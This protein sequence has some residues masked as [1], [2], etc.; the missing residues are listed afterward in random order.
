MVVTLVVLVVVG[1]LASLLAQFWTEILWFDSVDLRSV[2]ATQLGAQVLL[3][4]LSGLLAAGVVFSSL[5]IGYRTRPIYAPSM[6]GVETLDRYREGLEPARRAATIGIPLVVGLLTGLG[7][8]SQWETFLMWRNGQEFGTTDPQFGMDLGFFVFTLPWLT[9]LVGFF[10]LVLILGVLAAA[11]THYVYGGLQFTAQDRRT[12][13]A[14]RLHLSVLIALLVIVRAAGYWV[15]RYSLVTQT[16]DLMTGI[17]YTDA[18]AV[19]PTK[20]ILAVASLMCAVMFLSVI[21][22]KSWRLPV[23]GVVLLLLVSIVVGAIFP[24]LIQSLRVKPSEKSLE[25][26]YLSN[27]IAAT[28]TAYGLDDVQVEGYRAATEAT[29][30]QL[31]GDAATVPGI[32]LVDPN[33]V[34][35]TFQQLQALRNYYRFPDALDVDRYV[36][37]GTLSDTVLAVREMDLDGV[38]EG[39]RNWLNDHTVYTHGY[40]IVAAYGTR[41]GADGQPIFFEQDIPS[42][43]ALGE[44]QP[45][46]YFGEQ[47]PLYSIVGAPEGASPREF[48]YPDSSAGGQANYT[49]TGNGGVPIDSFLKRVAY[50]LKYREINFLLSDAVNSDSRVLDNRLPKDRVQR[51]A[52]WLTL[53]GNPYPAVVDGR[54]LWIIDGYTTSANYPNSRLTSMADVTADSIT[55]SRRS[56]SALESGQ[57]NYIRNSVKATVD[58]Y[59]GSVRL[60]QWDASDPILK[61]WMGAFPDVVEPLGNISGSLMSHLR[62]PEDLFKVQREILTRYHVTE[63][64]SFYGGQDF[65]RVPADPTQEMRNTDQPAYYLTLA[66][67]GQTEAEFSLTTTF[68]PSGDREVLSGFLAVD[69]NAGT[70]AGQRRD[71][72]G[73]MRMLE[74]PRDSNVRGPGQVQND[75]NSSNISSPRFSL[76]LSQFLNNARQQGSTVILGNLLTLPVGGGL[77]YVEPIYVQANASSAYP[78][79]RA[80]VAAFGD[81][82]AWSDTLGGALDGL[83][84][85]DSGATS[86]DSSTPTTPATPGTCRR[87][88]RAAGTTRSSIRRS[89][90]PRQRS[91]RRTPR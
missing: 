72:Y 76:T 60:Y 39:Q 36:V 23:I 90:M 11:F 47:S 61:A 54:L 2:F 22:T 88:P 57:L 42:T 73:T 52:P 19:L 27:N 3:G 50:G 77:L 31:R 43:G 82:L 45:R 56:V 79:S 29:Q 4:V 85:G 18:N 49:F 83:F 16:S 25:A 5:V 10:S 55:R 24:S 91:P 67:P 58:A 14:A 15:E 33:V 89:P 30:G 1:S 46:V 65:W 80:I 53:D 8:A 71:G 51:A 34:S 68:M 48:D 87:R 74:L 62:Y 26:P 78:L 35:P 81:K 21:W 17:Q 84:G 86:D 63:A 44:F 66:M 41:R 37:D 59:D 70:T 6:T 75:I 20:S 64:D 13:T 32:R 12:T 9:F 40:G 38:P 69:S 28:R 7:A